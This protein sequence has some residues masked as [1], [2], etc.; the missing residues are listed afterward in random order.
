MSDTA[1]ARKDHRCQLCDHPILAGEK[2]IRA[3]ITPSENIH[4]DGWHTYKAHPACDRA[5]LDSDWFAWDE[6]TPDP[7]EFR[8]EILGLSA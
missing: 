4:G 8:R 3:T 2:Y 7:G 1:T 5:Y 6:P